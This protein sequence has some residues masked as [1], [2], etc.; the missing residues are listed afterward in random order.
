MW[1]QFSQNFK[2]KMISFTYYCLTDVTQ[3]DYVTWFH[4]KKN[5]NNGEIIF[6]KN[7]LY[8]TTCLSLYSKRYWKSKVMKT[9]V[10]KKYNLL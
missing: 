7:M 6:L 3:H 2:A 8:Q 4:K 9:T 10:I 1:V 5:C